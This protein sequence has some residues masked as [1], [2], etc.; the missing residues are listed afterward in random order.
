MKY[1]LPTK[2][3]YGTIFYFVLIFRS[4]GRARSQFVRSS[5]DIWPL[6]SADAHKNELAVVID[7]S[8]LAEILL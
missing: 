4:I 7:F 6:F 1:T 5:D 8:N 3:H 2:F